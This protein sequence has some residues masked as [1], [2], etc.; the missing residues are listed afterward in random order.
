VPPDLQVNVSLMETEVEAVTV[1][2]GNTDN[3][4]GGSGGSGGNKDNGGDS[5]GGG[6]E[7]NLGLGI[8]VDS[9]V[10][11]GECSA[12]IVIWQDSAIIRPP[13]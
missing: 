11:T 10:E 8:M 1:G 13:F 2:N 9:G 6:T 5:N 7:N 3:G 4:S 12:Y